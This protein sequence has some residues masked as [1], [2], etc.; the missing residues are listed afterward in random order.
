MAALLFIY[1]AF[2]KNKLF[3]FL[4]RPF[5]TAPPD[6]FSFV[7][8]FKAAN[9]PIYSSCTALTDACELCHLLLTA[10]FTFLVAF[11]ACSSILY[12]NHAF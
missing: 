4:I 11:Q 6:P 5:A 2:Q 8:R 9:S 7:Y 1:R 12:S 3:N 10:F